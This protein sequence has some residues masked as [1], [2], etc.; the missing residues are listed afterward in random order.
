MLRRG[1]ALGE[2]GEFAEAVEGLEGGERLK[3][4]FSEGERGGMGRGSLAEEKG[5]RRSGC[6]A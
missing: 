1:V 3:F 2:C 5:L 4:E 6:G